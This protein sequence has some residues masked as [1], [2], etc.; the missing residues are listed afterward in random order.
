VLPLSLSPA[1]TQTPEAG[2]LPSSGHGSG[3]TRALIPLTPLPLA[4]EDHL[5]S[6][7]AREGEGEGVG[8]GRGC[9]DCDGDVEILRKLERAVADVHGYAPRQQSA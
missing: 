7:K 6:E 8:V 5:D 4:L 2:A 9:A 1:Q 3:L